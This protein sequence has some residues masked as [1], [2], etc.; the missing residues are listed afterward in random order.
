[1]RQLK[2]EIGQITEK[3]SVDKAVEGLVSKIQKRK[4]KLTK[5]LEDIDARSEVLQK[6]RMNTPMK[7]ICELETCSKATPTRCPMASW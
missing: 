3:Y 5:D 6:K 4:Q 7:K 1:M 2:D